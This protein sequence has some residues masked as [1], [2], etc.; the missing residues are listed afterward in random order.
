[1]RVTTRGLLIGTTIVVLLS[2]II[3][4]III[5]IEKYEVNWTENR[6]NNVSLGKYPPCYE[7]CGSTRNI[8]DEIETVGKLDEYKKLLDVYSVVLCQVK[9]INSNNVRT[10]MMDRITELIKLGGDTDESKSSSILE[11]YPTPCDRSRL[12]MTLATS[13][14]E[15]EIRNIESDASFTEEQKNKINRFNR[16]FYN[17]NYSV[18][19]RARMGRN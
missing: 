3:L 4:F 8:Y 2:I 9:H 10:M 19:S 11:M 1:M 13:L 17:N 18:I 7:I 12:F 14:I 5:R 15:K 16:S 6:R